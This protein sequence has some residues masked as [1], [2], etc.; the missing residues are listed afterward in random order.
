MRGRRR[1]REKSLTLG[2]SGARE[3][4]VETF[5]GDSITGLEWILILK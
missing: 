3:Y 4:N 2:D 1:R 5:L